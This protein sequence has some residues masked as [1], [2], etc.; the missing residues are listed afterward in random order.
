MDKGIIW[1]GEVSLG[2]PIENRLGAALGDESLASRQLSRMAVLG[3][4]ALPD[5][6]T[7]L[8][9]IGNR[10]CR[11]KSVGMYPVHMGIEIVTQ[12]ASL[13]VSSRAS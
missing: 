6:P 13:R 11:I 8:L 10:N 3:H 7:K 5:L 4:P 1:M 12:T 9:Q 2:L